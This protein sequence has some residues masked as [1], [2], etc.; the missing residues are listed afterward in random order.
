MSDVRVRVCVAAAEDLEA[1]MVFI[2]VVFVSLYRDPT[3]I[4][5]IERQRIFQSPEYSVVI[6]AKKGDEIVGC[7]VLQRLLF[8]WGSNAARVI[9]KVAKPGRGSAETDRAMVEFA[10]RHAQVTWGAELSREW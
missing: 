10:R 7:A 4:G 9:G 5:A 2:R 6:I 1:I 3:T 8:P